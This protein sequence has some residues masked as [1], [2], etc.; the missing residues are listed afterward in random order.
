[1]KAKELFKKVEATNF[2]YGATHAGAMVY[3]TCNIVNADDPTIVD[4]VHEY[5]PYNNRFYSW[6]G[7]ASTVAFEFGQDI[8]DLIGSGKLKYSKV[9]RTFYIENADWIIRF[10]VWNE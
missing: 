8:C 9:S 6:N 1:M 3:I 4:R 7:F 10:Y 5:K 2:I